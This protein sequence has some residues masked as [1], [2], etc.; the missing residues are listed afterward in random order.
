MSK[1]E[2]GGGSSDVETGINRERS[3]DGEYEATSGKSNEQILK[4]QKD[5]L[6][7]Q[8]AKLDVVLGVV[9]ATKFEAE[10]FGTEARL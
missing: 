4:Q 5:Q 1:L 2:S 7:A 6:K 3:E 8:D 9:Q 10:N